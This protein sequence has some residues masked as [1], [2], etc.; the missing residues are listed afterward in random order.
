MPGLLERSHEESA[1]RPGYPPTLFGATKGIGALGSFAL[2][3]E[4]ISAT[5]LVVL[6]V[7]MGVLSY[8]EDT[9]FFFRLT[10][11]P[12]WLSGPAA[13]LCALIAWRG[14]LRPGPLAPRVWVLLLGVANLALFGVGVYVRFAP[15]LPSYL[16]DPFPFHAI[17][18]SS[19][20]AAAVR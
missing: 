17:V 3:S 20:V 6:A 11:S 1:A 19:A 16:L 14:S 15:R 7:L 13:L 18:L 8:G 5:S 2:P 9:R 12:M 10:Y 4:T